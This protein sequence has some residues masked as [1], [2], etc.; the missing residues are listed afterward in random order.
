MRFLRRDESGGTLVEYGMVAPLLMLLIVGAI[1][2]SYLLFQ[3]Q[4]AAKATQIGARLAAVMD[5]AAPN[6]ANFDGTGNGST[7]KV[8]DACMTISTG[9]INPACNFGTVTCTST[10][11]TCTGGTCKDNTGKA[12]SGAPGATFTTILKQ[13]QIVLPQLAATNLQLQ[14]TANGFG[15]VGFP[16]SANVTIS[17]IGLKYQFF[18]LSAFEPVFPTSMS[19]PTSSATLVSE[20]LKSS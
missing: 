6:L 9:T 8:G 13:M 4:G 12:I 2:L 14:Y 18:A 15:V 17:I 11:C 16:A 7:A 5:R 10:T 19:I 20:D 1:D 3:W